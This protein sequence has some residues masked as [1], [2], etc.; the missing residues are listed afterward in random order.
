MP[1]NVPSVEPIV[2]S[3][4][5]IMPSNVPSVEPIV[6]PVTPTPLAIET[7]VTPIM[8]PIMPKVPPKVQQ[9]QQPKMPPIVPKVTPNEPPTPLAIET[10]VTPIVAPP[11][12]P[13]VAPPVTPIVAP[14]VPPIIEPVIAPSL[15]NKSPFDTTPATTIEPLKPIM[16]NPETPQYGIQGFN[17]QPQQQQQPQQPQYVIQNQLMGAPPQYTNPFTQPTQFG[18]FGN[19]IPPSASSIFTPQYNGVQPWLMPSNNASLSELLAYNSLQRD[20]I[21][22]NTTPESKILL[23]SNPTI[24]DEF[25]RILQTGNDKT[26]TDFINNVN[27]KTKPEVNTD[28]K[29][30]TTDKTDYITEKLMKTIDKLERQ[31]EQMK[32]DL[33]MKKFNDLS[34]RLD[35]SQQQLAQQQQQQQQQQQMQPQQMQQQ[36]MQPYPLL[37]PQSPSNIINNTGFPYQ[38]PVYPPMPQLP[39]SM[40]PITIT[41]VNTNTNQGPTSGVAGNLMTLEEWKKKQEEDKKK[42]DT[43]E[44]A[45]TLCKPTDNQPNDVT[46]C[47]LSEENDVIL[48]DSEE[49]DANIITGDTRDIELCDDTRPDNFIKACE[50]GELEIDANLKP[51]KAED[52]VDEDN[53]LDDLRKRLDALK[54]G[55]DGSDDTKK[56][57]NSLVDLLTNK[58]KNQ[59]ENT[60]TATP[61]AKTTGTATGPAGV[62]TQDE[63][64]KELEILFKKAQDDAAKIRKN[65]KAKNEI[66]EI[67]HDKEAK[68]IEEAQTQLAE[69]VKQLEEAKKTILE[70]EL[71]ELA[72]AK[73]TA[74]ATIPVATTPVATTP[75]ATTPVATTTTPVGGAP[76]NSPICITFSPVMSPIQICGS[77]LG[78]NEE[79]INLLKNQK[80]NGPN[81]S[82]NASA[83]A[84][85]NASTN[86]EEPIEKTIDIF[87]PCKMIADYEKNKFT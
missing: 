53:T 81:A 5:P 45:V 76:G 63:K 86:V 20:Y 24:Q 77:T 50:D 39:F 59:N 36:Q 26:I 43:S 4:E 31:S 13:I 48:C 40:P 56:N 34:E 29:D 60:G 66:T 3:V 83:N 10:Q 25:K 85:Q 42:Q 74:L 16:A 11:V 82:P 18:P 62:A 8:Q 57:L 7:P 51:I 78:N 71:A 54:N 49:V 38:S 69:Q 27:K 17:Q 72:K 41:N 64:M 33:I 6:P 15:L 19:P 2:P 35:K 79:I 58:L 30:G 65:N 73:A 61:T 22:K 23:E 44:N 21:E 68:E 67:L 46:L 37:Y 84:S 12:T 80:G 47:K 87:N 75:V 1:S 14:P 70:T 28:K 52:V 9:K 32:E 55:S